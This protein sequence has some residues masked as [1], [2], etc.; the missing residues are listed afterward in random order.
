MFVSGIS[1]PAKLLPC[2]SALRKK[3]LRANY[4]AYLNR[5]CIVQ[6]QQFPSPNGQGWI[7]KGP[8]EIQVDWMDIHPAPPAVLN[9]TFCG[10]KTDCRYNQC[11]CKKNGMKCTGICTCSKDC[12]N[13]PLKADF[14][15][16]STEEGG[17][18]VIEPIEPDSD[19]DE[20]EYLI[21]ISKQI[22]DLKSA[23]LLL[24]FLFRSVLIWNCKL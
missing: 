11:C 19:I 14:G 12:K 13:M 23:S 8:D 1:E 24:F 6:E 7:I 17:L 2:S 4:Q 3:I 21:L 10:C 5:H 16:I 18:K 15:A 22:T 9:L 20:L